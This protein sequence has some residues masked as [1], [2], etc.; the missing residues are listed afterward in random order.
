MSVVS[1]DFDSNGWPDID[2]ACDSSQSACFRNNHYGTFTESALERG[3]ALNDDGMEQAGMGLAAGDYNL[4]GIPDLFLVTGH[5]FPEVESW[6]PRYRY[7]SPRL[8]FRG[9][10]SESL[11]LLDNVPGL[12]E[13]HSSRGCAFGDFDNDGD[14]DIL[15][16]NMDAP[17]F[18][19]R[20]P[21]HCTLRQQAPGAG[22]SQPVEL[23]L[24]QRLAPPLWPRLGRL[25]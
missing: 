25:R 22:R 4:D 6:V 7:R 9:L 2:V 24:R 10:G 14:V 5:V 21:C 23:L 11:E 8:L 18:G 16:W 17:P 12:T 3:L 20:R 1:A 13:R 15:I 19:H